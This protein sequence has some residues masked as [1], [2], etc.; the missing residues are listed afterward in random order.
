MWSYPRIQCLHQS[1]AGVSAA[2]NT[3]ITNASR[4]AEYVTFLDADDLWEPDA[5]AV[6]IAALA[7]DPRAVGAHGLACEIDSAG[8]RIGGDRR[9]EWGRNRHSVEGRQLRKTD[10]HE[11]TNFACVV[12][13]PCFIV[14]TIVIRHSALN[15]AGLF[16]TSL[17]YAEDHDMWLRISVQ[18]NIIYVDHVVLRYRQHAASAMRNARDTS[19]R[20]GVRLRMLAS[21][22]IS[23]EQR[24]LL[25]RGI[26]F[27]YRY[28]AEQKFQWMMG[29]LRARKPLLAARNMVHGLRNYFRY[30]SLIR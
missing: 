19:P 22:Q 28:L 18:G 12:Y 29:S 14:G 26:A 25:R 23:S 21:P 11:P 17:T 27:W 6:L 10:P 8:N 7:A 20:T 9:A 4:G 3:G 13:D 30:F 1:N 15:A 16:D 5:L 2:R 24:Q